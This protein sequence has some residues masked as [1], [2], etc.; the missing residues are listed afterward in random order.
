MTKPAR[1][2][3]LVLLL[4]CLGSTAGRGLA[5]Q[6]PPVDRFGGRT[7]LRLAEPGKFF[8]THSDGQR[9]WL[10]TPEGN[11]FLAPGVCH[12]TSAGEYSPK[13][14]TNPYR[15]TITT[16][17]GSTDR[18]AET[19][20]KRLREWGFTT[21]AA[22]CG[23]ELRGQ[24]PYT[25]ELSMSRSLWDAGIPDVFGEEFKKYVADRASQAA[26]YVD[27]PYLLG[28]YLDNE[29]PWSPD[30]RALP[31]VFQRYIG[32]PAGSPGKQKL[33]EFFRERYATPR[34]FCRVWMLD[35]GDWAAVAAAKEMTPRDV[36]RAKEDREAFTLLV[37]RQY[38]KETTEAI[39]RHDPNHRILGC[40]IVWRTV[41]KVVVQACG[42]ACDVVSINYYE[43]GPM[44]NA[45]LAVA[46]PGVDRMSPDP[47]FREYHELT[48]KPLMITEFGFRAEDSGMPNTFPPGWLVQPTV[49]TQKE[50]AEKYRQYVTTWIGSPYFVGYHWFQYADE[51]KA[52][53]F[54]GEDGNYGLVN[55]ND[56]PY[57]EFVEV[58]REVN[59]QAWELHRGK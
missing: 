22:W 34:E 27:D 38:F 1:R 20:G 3:L 6:T 45:A 54:D 23:N 46:V 12:V 9:W 39:R 29:L 49:K 59:R 47:S 5:Q 28:Y 58:V 41:P 51:P 55:N 19:T 57:A 36:G 43:V 44:G 10:V 37:A 4:G 53:R 8:R 56:E 32:L 42:E 7:D 17:Y 40:R 50:R 35:V 52:G 25:I 21:L 2:L 15:E 16:K 11:A 30:W 14:K 48:G 18:W 26:Q 13:S 24:F 31:E 33:V